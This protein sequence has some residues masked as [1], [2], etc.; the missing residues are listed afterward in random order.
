MGGLLTSYDW[1]LVFAI[2]VPVGVATLVF[3]RWVA[4]SPKRPRPF[5]W[6]GQ[7]L[8]VAGLA[9]LVYGLIEGGHAG[10][11]SAPAVIALVIAVA[12]S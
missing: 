11:G 5:D 12:A 10:F 1:R 7:V 6:A 3:L 4:T 2:N 9:G 8:A